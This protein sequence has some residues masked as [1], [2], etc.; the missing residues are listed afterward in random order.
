MCCSLFCVLSL[1]AGEAAAQEVE[2]EGIVLEDEIE[3]RGMKCVP[4]V[5]EVETRRPI[6]VQCKTDYAVAGVEL[7][8]RSGVA[9]SKWEKIELAPGEK[10]T[11]R[12]SI[13]CTATAKRGS[14]KVYVFA[15]NANNKVIARVGRHTTP[16]TIRVVEHSSLAA[17]ALP[18]QTAPERCFD[19]GEC[20]PEMLGTS[21]CP[22]TKAA[23]PKV[24]K[25]AWGQTCNFTRECQASLECVAG[26]CE[27]PAK[28]DSDADC[29]AG[30]E[31]D[32]GLCHVP[33][34]E[35]LATRLG[36]PKHHWVGLHV[37][38]DFTMLREA[39]GVCGNTTE[40]SKD[41]ACFEG[42]NPYT[43]SPNVT[44]AGHLS[45]SVY[46]AT[47][48]ALLSYEYTVGRLALGGRLGW[49]FRGAPRDFTPI[50]I[51]ARG[52]YSV[53]K[54]PLE[55]RFRTYLGLSAG[56]AQVDASGSVTVV[57][58]TSM[59]ISERQTCAS[60]TN[61]NVVRDQYLSQPD[62]AVR[63]TLNAFRSGGKF[64]FGPTLMMVFALSN[65]SAVVFNL[66]A[67][68]PEVVFEPTIG[69]AMGL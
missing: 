32:D 23:A 44:E 49:A 11:F 46:F 37:G 67:M 65:E 13:P 62:L 30:G 64:F 29:P 5:K 22:G 45:S 42:G 2:P 50:H 66:N 27:T 52:L 26:S 21:A 60:E 47:V 51:E 68:L 54:D 19:A 34:A 12:G 10:N 20:P 41:Y 39:S 38:A 31:C 48:R 59:S 14:L 16:L 1:V 61:P 15:R 4:E 9:K 7:R 56:F 6:P 43:G 40:D 55:K 28:C 18:G 63:R 36:P 8:Y 53:T 24:T 3:V 25:K 57:D 69:Y 35:E 17:P 33:D 58:C